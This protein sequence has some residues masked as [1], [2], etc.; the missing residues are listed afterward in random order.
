M[1]TSASFPDKSAD[2]VG[3]LSSHRTDAVSVEAARDLIASCVSPVAGVERLPLRLVSG[4]VLAEDA[5]SRQAVP[6]FDN[7][8]MDGFAFSSKNVDLSE[9]LALK[10][11]GYAGAGHPYSGQ[12]LPGECIRIMTGAVVPEGCD[13]VVPQ[14]QVECGDRT[15]VVIPAASVRPGDHVRRTGE[16]LPEGAVVVREGTLLRP[17]HVGLLASAGLAEVIVRRRVTVALLST[18]DELQTPGT[19]LKKG[20]LYDSNRPMLLAMLERLGCDVL[21]MG[22]VADDPE[23]LSAALKQACENTDAIVTSGGVSVGTADVTRDVIARLG[24]V[25][26]RSVNMLPG[27]PLTFGRIHGKSRNVVLFGLPGN[28]VAVVVSF[29]FFVRNA[30]LQMMGAHPVSLPT[31]MAQSTTSFSK[32]VGRTEFQRG[33]VSRSVDG[34]LTVETTG[35]QGS[36]MLRSVT[37]AN[38]IVVLPEEWETVQ[39]GEW[40]EVILL[41]GLV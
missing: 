20:C 36:A 4:R 19:L 21:D 32:R 35:E 31:V 16:Q 33:N 40:V 37:D 2:W 14:E 9:P 29:Y 5:V 27:R 18:G 12:V 24:E 38:G 41:E 26:F 13:T 15:Q 34:R 28:P 7:S 8:A 30:L 17:A 39:P 23:A 11:A 22:I 6:A 1:T 25:V 3:S 10:V